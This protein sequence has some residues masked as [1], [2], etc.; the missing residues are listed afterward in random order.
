MCFCALCCVQYA[1]ALCF[2]RQ[3]RL[4]YVP[5][6]FQVGICAE[7]LITAHFSV[8]TDMCCSEIFG[9][10]PDISKFSKI[11]LV[12]LLNFWIIAECTLQLLTFQLEHQLCT[13]CNVLHCITGLGTWHSAI[14]SAWQQSGVLGAAVWE[15]RARSGL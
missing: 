7:L 3:H 15:R 4:G 2:V 10:P 1:N 13:F 14:G 5:F 9:F 8:C 6:E 11:V 12:F